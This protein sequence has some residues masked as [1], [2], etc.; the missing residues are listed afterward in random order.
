[1]I[2]NV[3]PESFLKF[4][5]VKKNSA[6]SGTRR[7]SR[8][9]YRSRATWIQCTSSHYTSFLVSLDSVRARDSVVICSLC[10]KVVGSGRTN[11]RTKEFNLTSLLHLVQEA[12]ISRDSVLPRYC[13]LVQAIITPRCSHL[14]H[15]IMRRNAA[16]HHC[17][18]LIQS[19]IIRNSALRH[20]CLLVHAMFQGTQ[21]DL[22]A[23]I[24]Y[25]PW[26]QGTQP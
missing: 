7:K 4:Q 25:T 1:M 16:P 21:L 6:Y 12:T 22:N 14:V 2:S 17:C 24:W 9:R 23:V 8:Q 20:F 18:H 26:C 13:R 15:A 10:R 3:G 11:R 19:I 5:F